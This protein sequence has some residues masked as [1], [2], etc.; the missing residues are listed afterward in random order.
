M[1]A[2]NVVLFF[3]LEF[4]QD[5]RIGMHAMCTFKYS[6]VTLLGLHGTRPQGEVNVGAI[7]LHAV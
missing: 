2:E 3:C 6:T 1:A 7:T 5:R 4:E